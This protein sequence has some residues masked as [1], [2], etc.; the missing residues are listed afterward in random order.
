MLKNAHGTVQAMNVKALAPIA[1][2]AALGFGTL[3]PHA[4]TAPQKVGFVDVNGV[5]TADSRYAAVKTLQDKATAELNPLDA[6]VKAIQAKGTG[7]TAAEKDQ[8]NQ[9]ITTIQSKAKD[10]DA[11]IAKLVDPI[12]NSVNT[13]VTAAAKAQGFSVVMDANVARNS[14]LVIYADQSADLTDA[15]KKGLKP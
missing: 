8:M 4:Q 12:T 7:A 14:G 9:L 1:I 10:Y 5:A 2:V 6:Q 13:A 3:V 11:Q 15:V